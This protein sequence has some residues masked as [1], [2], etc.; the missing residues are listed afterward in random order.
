MI[1]IPIIVPQNRELKEQ[2]AREDSLYYVEHPIKHYQETDH[3]KL[4]GSITIFGFAFYALIMIILY[5]KMLE[6]KHKFWTFIYWFWV[7]LMSIP[8]FFIIKH[9]CQ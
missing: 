3:E 5:L 2:Q 7:S 9:I 4:V 8:I 1:F 6:R